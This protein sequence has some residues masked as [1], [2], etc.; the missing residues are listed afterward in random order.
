MRE[1]PDR[2]K[3]KRPGVIPGVRPGVIPGVRPR[4]TPGVTP[5]GR[6]EVRPI[7]PPKP[8]YDEEE[9]DPTLGLKLGKVLL[10][11]KLLFG[12][13]L[14][15]PYGRLGYGYGPDR[16]IRPGVIPGV[17]PGVTPGVRPGVIPRVKPGIGFGLRP[18]KP[19]KPY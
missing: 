12:G 14:G 19:P 17:R 4:V 6:P 7:R 3:K 2:K 18:G 13:V 16:Y 9:Q 15:L 8:Y 11:K 10:A 5:G 1:N